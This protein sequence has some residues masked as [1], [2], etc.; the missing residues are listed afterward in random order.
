MAPVREPLHAD[1][2]ADHYSTSDELSVRR[3]R[4]QLRT[5]AHPLK[6]G[7]RGDIEQRAAALRFHSNIDGVPHPCVSAALF[8]KALC[9]WAR[10]PR[11]GELCRSASN[12]GEWALFRDN[13]SVDRRAP[14]VPSQPVNVVESLSAKSDERELIASVLRKDRKAVARLVAAHIDAVYTYARHRLAPHAD[15]V[16]DVVQEVFLAALKRLAAFEG[17]SS[18]RTW[19]LAIARH[20]IEDIYRQRLRAALALDLNSADDEP[21]SN[22]VPLDEQIDKARAGAKTRR[23]LERMPERYALVLL[24]RYWEQRSARDVAAAI[25]TTEKSVERLLARARTKFKELW[26]KD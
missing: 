8:R 14:T 25:G 19:L 11:I 26:L 3:E 17:Q 16:D 1:L 9:V 20:K 5:P 15:L 21:I 23:V 6:H 12:K 22:E 4:L 2:Y 18:L 7:D 24:W 13:Y 10:M